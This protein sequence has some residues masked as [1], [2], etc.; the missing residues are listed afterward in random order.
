MSTLVRQLSNVF[1]LRIGVTIAFTAL[2][3]VAVTPGPSLEAWQIAALAFAVLMSSASAGGYNQYMERDLDARMSRTHNRPFVTGALRHGPY[4][5]VILCAMLMA[6]VGMAAW[7]LNGVAALY[8]FL[9]AF[10]YS[11]VYTSWLKRRTWLN[12]V[13]GGLAGSFAVLAGAAAVDPALGALPIIFAVVLFFWTPSHFWS[14]A[15]VLHKDYEAAG[16]PML[17]VVVGDRRAA[18]VILVNTLMLVAASLLPF[19]FGMGWIYL[20]G[21]AIGG[22]LFLY[23]NVQLVR[24][25]SVAMARSNFHAS[26]VQLTLLLAAAIADVQ[27]LG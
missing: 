11:V 20:L 4:F 14:L 18:Q 7:M 8:V 23:K 10:T 9:G 13:F 27:L 26:L 19:W 25:P 6:S 17:P 24:D 22:A 12:I 21:A 2:A 15:I 3:G 5:L 16:V 1:K